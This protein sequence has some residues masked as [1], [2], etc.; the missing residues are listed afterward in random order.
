MYSSWLIQTLLFLFSMVDLTVSLS[1]FIL[2]LYI[3]LP[4]SR[5]PLSPYFI[6][7]RLINFFPCIEQIYGNG[8]SMF[9][10]KSTVANEIYPFL[11]HSFSN[12]L[13]F[14]FLCSISLNSSPHLGHILLDIL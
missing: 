5:H 12:S 8:V 2:D 6:L 9:S 1:N 14:S 13:I 10:Y 7:C 11:L 3:N 4:H